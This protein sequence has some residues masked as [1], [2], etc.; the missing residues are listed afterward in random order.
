M[1]I[2]K[3]EI[4]NKIIYRASYRGSKE[5]DILMTGFVNSVINKL[6]LSELNELDYWNMYFQN[7][8][9]RYNYLY[10]DR[11]IGKIG[12]QTNSKTRAQILTKLEEVLRTKQVK[13]RSSRLYEEL[14]TFVWKNGKAQAMRGQNDDL[15]MALAIGVWLY[16]T[17]PQLSK[18]GTDI[19][20]AMLS[21][22]VGTVAGAMMGTTTVTSYVESG[23]GVKAGGKTGMTSLV[24]GLLFLSCIFFAPL[25][26]SLP[27]QIDGAAL[28]FVSVLFIRNITDIDWNDIAES[29]PAIL[30]MIAMPLTYS[31]SNGI[32]LA[33]VSYA[34][35]KIFTGKFSTTS[36]AIWVIAILSVVS[37][38]VA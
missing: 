36:P 34:L 12:F 33:F 37:F 30:A 14:K 35:I 18:T 10:G 20:K 9:D 3:E 19:N 1:S 7:D 25:A 16:D 5:M 6:N 32:A 2:N 28:L 24:I 38:A 17:S 15:I 26:T 23:A 27:K 22:S 8:R 11:E 21:D 29:A 13:I 4:K 31:I